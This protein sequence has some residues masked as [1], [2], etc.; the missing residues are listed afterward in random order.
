M[1]KYKIAN[2]N[3]CERD[4]NAAI[5]AFRKQIKQGIETNRKGARTIK[6]ATNKKP[7]AI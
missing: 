4:K 3:K 1:E 7:K 2:A 5:A 6:V